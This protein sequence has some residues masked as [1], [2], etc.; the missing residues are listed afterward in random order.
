VRA[1]RRTF[2]GFYAD[3]SLLSADVEH[4]I[5]LEL[6]LLKRASSRAFFENV[7]TEYTEAIRR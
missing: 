5:E 4:S 1:E 6:P 7:E 3:L 2:V